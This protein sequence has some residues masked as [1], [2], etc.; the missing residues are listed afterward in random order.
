MPKNC[1]NGQAEILSAGDWA[2]LKKF[3]RGRFRIFLYIAYLTGERWGAICKLNVE[4][5]YVDAE[6]R[7]VRSSILFRASTRKDK[8]AREVPIHSELRAILESHSPPLRGFLFSSPRDRDR[9]IT[10]RSADYALRQLAKKSGL[11]NRGI[12]THSTRRTFITNLSRKGIDIRT[13]QQLTGHRNVNALIRYIE[14]D[15]ERAA[16]AVNALDG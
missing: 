8:R 9:A 1:R 13:I 15:P 2:K 12:S 11:S 14:S 7:K 10:L 16:N 5:V 6:K 4:D 3:A